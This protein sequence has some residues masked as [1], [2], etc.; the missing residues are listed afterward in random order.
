[1][2]GVCRPQVQGIARARF[3]KGASDAA[4]LDLGG[5]GACANALIQLSAVARTTPENSLM[6]FDCGTDGSEIAGF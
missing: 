1:M 2:I 5:H 6:R 3:V 4:N